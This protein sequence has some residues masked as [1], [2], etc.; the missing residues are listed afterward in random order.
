[1]KIAI[2][3]RSEWMYET[4]ELLINE[5]FEIGLIITSK[6]APEYK[7]T[8]DDFEKLAKSIDASFLYTAKLGDSESLSFIRNQNKCGIALSVN[9]SGL[10]PQSVIDCFDLG[11]LNAHGGDLPRYRGNACQAWAIINGENRIGL[12][13][14]KMIGGELDNGDIV[15]RDFFSIGSKTKV[16]ECYLWME[17]RIPA[18]FAEAVT[19]LADN[20]DFV[21]DVQSKQKQDAL[22]CYPRQPED[23]RINWSDS[24]IN[25]QRLI[26][27]SSEPFSG[28]FAEYKGE[29]II[30]WD[31]ELYQDDEVYIA[32]PGQVT[33]LEYSSDYIVV[34]TGSGKLKLKEIEYMGVRCKPRTIIKSIRKRLT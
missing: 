20:G 4:I 26:N 5:G 24:S 14:H 23:G 30:I 11:I 12:C 33:N 18:L 6:A 19:K 10:I 16:G 27:A 9:Y 15:A 17:K 7:V 8:S 22:R 28:A 25:I 31:S 29:N 1:M 32:I 34:A 13:I 21:L 3:G 2:I